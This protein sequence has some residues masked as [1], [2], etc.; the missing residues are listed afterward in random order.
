MSTPKV[1]ENAQFGVKAFDPGTQEL[2]AV[3]PREM[4]PNA[5]TYLQEVVDSGLAS[6][7]TDRFERYLADLHGTRFCVATPGC[8]QAIFAAA[9]GLDFEPGD[10]II[11][12]PITDYGSVAGLLIEGYIPVFADTEPGTALL[13][14]RTIEPLITDRTRAVMCV[15]KLGLP[16]DMD[17][18]VDLARRH[19]LIVIEDVCQA[20][21][22]T[23]KGRLAGTLGDLACFSFDAE[24]TMG[25]D[26]GGAVLTNDEQIHQRIKY[27]AISRGA[28]KEPGFGRIHTCRGFATR[29]PQCT[30]ATCLANFEILPRQVENRRKMAAMLD[31]RIREIPGILPYE[32]PEGRTHTYWMYGFSIEPDRFACTPEQFA[33]EIT[34][35]GIPGVGL[36]K[37]YLM[38]EALPFLA[39]YVKR[40]VYPF[41]SP[42]SSRTYRYA[43]DAVPNAQAFLSTWI[44][45]FW[46]EKYNAGHIEYIAG[47]IRDVAARC[48]R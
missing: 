5:M 3:F 29:M 28:Y 33:S 19:N 27:R 45:W 36:G 31:D 47:I 1:K 6:D 15:H 21:M 4:G 48:A 43:G 42:P 25:G 41:S 11:V 13:S 40:G 39:E 12:S 16:C 17:P 24:K 10:E 14:A 38:P 9:L 23:Y 32:V 44:R 37:Y 20:V 34:V 26:I 35:K 46:T 8:T 22:A 30:A 7:M 2:P 18:I